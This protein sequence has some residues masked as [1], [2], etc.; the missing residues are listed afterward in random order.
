MSKLLFLADCKQQW[1][2]NKRFSRAPAIKVFHDERFIATRTFMQDN[3]ESSIHVVIISTKYGFI[4]PTTI[5]GTY[6]KT[7]DYEE[8]DRF[9]P[10][11]M[12]QWNRHIDRWLNSDV[13]DVF[14]AATGP[15]LY[16]LQR[17]ELP[18]LLVNS[19]IAPKNMYAPFQVRDWLNN[20]E[21]Y[22]YTADLG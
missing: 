16:A 12:K 21:I 14:I 11:L 6:S 22:A 10:A 1:A 15:H 7:W 20:K 19:N 3:P 4:D 17:V 2:G 13:D 18:L 8:V 5:I 9:F